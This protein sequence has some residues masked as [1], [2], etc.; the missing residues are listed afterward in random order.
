MNSV[1]SLFSSSSHSQRALILRGIMTMCC[2]SQLSLL[3]A[4]LSMANRI[5]P[6]TLFPREVSLRVLRYL[7]AISL[8]RAAQVSRLWRSLADNDMLWRNMCE[9]HIERKCEKCGW[10]LP[11]LTERRGGKGSPMM[12]GSEQSTP[13]HDEEYRSAA[14]ASGDGSLR[15][16]VTAAANAAALERRRHT[17]VQSPSPSRS[18]SPANLPDTKR[19]RLDGDVSAPTQRSKYKT[20]P[21]KAVYC[22]RLVIERNWRRGRHSVRLFQGHTDGVMCLAFREKVSGMGFP[23]LI[24]G[25]YDRT[26]RVWNVR[27]GQ[28]LCTLTGHAR[29]VRCL[30]F[31][32]AKLITG[33]MD[34]T[35]KIWNWRTGELLRTLE[36][37][38]QG[39]VS[40]NYNDFI[41]ASGSADS[42]IR[43]WN[44]RTRECFSLQGHRDWVNAV[45]LWSGP[46]LAGSQ[47]DKMPPMF[48]FS[49]SD[50]GTIRLWDLQTRET[51]LVFRGHV[52]Q[53]QSLKLVMMDHASVRKLSRGTTTLPRHLSPMAPG[54]DATPP[55][56]PAGYKGGPQPAPQPSTASCSYTPSNDTGGRVTDASAPP[57]PE[58]FYYASAEGSRTSYSRL[59]EESSSRTRPMPPMI[60]T[61]QQ[62]LSAAGI[63]SALP[64]SATMDDIE[65]GIYCHDPLDGATEAEK[66]ADSCKGK[67][68]VLVTG[69]LDNT[70]RLW[71]VRTGQCFRTLFGHVEG[72]WGVDV[73]PL[74]IVSASHDRT[75]KIWD[76]D[77]VQCQ[78][79]LVG[80]RAA[81]TCIALGDDKIVSGSDDGDVRVWSFA[82][83]DAVDDHTAAVAPDGSLVPNTADVVTAQ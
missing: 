68:P 44:F 45:Q 56:P 27:T 10:G 22:E 78:S 17:P 3:S 36:G 46:A 70:L 8:G 7:D 38:T 73:D 14:T 20:R 37:H 69:S 80:H 82:P 47:E 2:F 62:R 28:M 71:D 58:Q 41:L 48:L 49:A 55:G 39:I 18:Q 42:S 35:L 31:D 57:I 79:T 24:T 11:L 64:L 5:D 63:V 23:V 34:R 6:F 66:A 33:S 54:D 51:I 26:V 60:A 9:Q 65:D 83:S 29:G 50:D 61:T 40:L 4:E 32:D 81:V 30:Q 52:G 53:V 25:S 15:R 74:R 77:T 75:I 19:Q 16:S 43:V 67:R 59:G 13:V 72:V 1:W 12:T 21:W 76:R